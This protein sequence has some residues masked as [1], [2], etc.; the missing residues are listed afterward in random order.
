MSY[1]RRITLPLLAAATLGLSSIAL[2][3]NAVIATVNGKNITQ[4]D[5]DQFIAANTS[6]QEVAREDVINELITR[7]LVYQD[8][9]RQGLEKDPKVKAAIEAAKANVI[10]GAALEKVVS[11]PAVGDA[12]MRKLYQE[13]IARLDTREFKARHI[14]VA[15]KDHAE[16]LITELDMGGNFSELAKKHSSDGS[17][18]EGGDLG[19][20]APQQMVPEFSRAVM[21][22]DKGKYTKAPVQSQFGWHVVMLDDTRKAEPPSYEKV[23][24]QLRQIIER[25]RLNTY[26]QGLREKGKVTLK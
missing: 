17:A 4:Q 19:W 12:E 10:L 26:L 16:R 24:P 13:E 21:G 25:Q 5:Y 15:E 1:I 20:F 18:S 6:G 7:E 8:A 23:K 14:L 3:N 2:A 22:L 9:S 11:T